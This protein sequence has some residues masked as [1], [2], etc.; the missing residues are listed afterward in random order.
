MLKHPHPDL[1]PHAGE[2]EER[3]PIDADDTLRV[4]LAFANPPAALRASA[5]FAKGAKRGTAFRDG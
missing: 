1:P 4:S 3:G 5:P 2:G